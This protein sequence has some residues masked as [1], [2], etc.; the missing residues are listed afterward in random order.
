VERFVR[1]MSIDDLHSR[2]RNGPIP[3]ISTSMTVL[4]NGEIGRHTVGVML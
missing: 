1:K 4:P 3:D 2:S